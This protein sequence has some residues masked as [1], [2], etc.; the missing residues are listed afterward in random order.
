MW[1][2]GSHRWRMGTGS[3]TSRVWASRLAVE[4]APGGRAAAKKPPV[5]DPAAHGGL[6]AERL[7]KDPVAGG[8]G[9]V[10]SMRPQ[11]DGRL[12]ARMGCL[13]PSQAPARGI[14]AGGGSR[15]RMLPFLPDVGVS[16]EAR[17]GGARGG[18]LGC[19]SFL[20]SC[21]FCRSCRLDCRSRFCHAQFGGGVADRVEFRD[22]HGLSLLGGMC[23]LAA[24]V[25][26]FA[27]FYVCAPHIWGGR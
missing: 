3:C 6:G 21:R 22:V 18:R 2:V 16:S 17:A 10:G 11:H 19:L 13:T 24:R 5:G 8:N 9:G 23:P 26:V 4:T 7:L 25:A 27:A 14:A 1:C 12:G 20:R 15:G